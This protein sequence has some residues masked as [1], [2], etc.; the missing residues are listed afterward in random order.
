M[1]MSP[2]SFLFPVLCL[3]WPAISTP[4]E[5]EVAVIAHKSVSQDTL[6]RGQLLDVFSGDVDRWTDGVRIVVKDLKLK[7]EVRDAFY[8]FLGKRPSRMKSIWLKRMLSGE[9]ERPESLTSEEEMLARVAK[10]PGAIGFISR[11]KV[12]DSV[13]LL[14]LI[15]GDG[16]R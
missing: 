15:P 5:T 9:G 13:K 2:A 4:A 7:G 14:L 10:T 16:A 6:S 8:E 1:R 3:A 12:T 11:A